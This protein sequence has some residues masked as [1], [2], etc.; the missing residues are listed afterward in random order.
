MKRKSPALLKR[1]PLM[2]ICCVAVAASPAQASLGL[3]PYVTGLSLPIAFVQDP[4]DKTVQYVVEQTGLIKVIKDGVL[5][6]TPFL[7]ATSWTF[8]GGGRGLLGLAFRPDYAPTGRSFMNVTN[9][10]G[11]TV[12]ARLKRSTGNPLVADP[13]SRFDFVWPGTPDVP[14]PHAYIYQ[15]YANHN[16]GT[17]VFGPD[18]YLYVGMG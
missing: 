5:L 8:A 2:L 11:H 3:R 17:I 1:I 14:G 4:S 13:A 16:G 6:S 18:G 9:L 10:Q 7:N 12:V 15:P